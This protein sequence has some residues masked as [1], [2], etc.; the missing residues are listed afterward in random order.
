[1]KVVMPQMGES[2]VEGKLERWLVREGDTIKHDQP[3][4][5]VST[6]K[7]D[8]EI[9]SPCEGKIV[10][11]LVAEGE[12]VAVGCEL[13]VIEDG[14]GKPVVQ[15]ASSP[16]TP[17]SPI[18]TLAPLSGEKK[19]ELPSAATELSLEA[20]SA[21][22]SPAVRK[23]A[24]KYHVDLSKVKGTGMGGR[25]T[26]QDLSLIL[27]KEI[28]EEM[29]PEV[30][31]TPRKET[32]IPNPRP[33]TS[34]TEFSEYK[35]PHYEPKE[36]DQVVPFSRL[37][38]MISE[39]MV[40]SKRTAPHVTTVAEV[41]MMRVARLRE[42]KKEYAKKQFGMELTY[43]PFVLSATLAAISAHPVMNASVEGEALIIKKDINLGIA[44]DTERGLLVP[45][46]RRAQEKPLLVLSRLAADLAQKA[47]DGTLSPDE[48]TGGSFTVTNPGRTG[49]LFGTPI[50]F[51]PQ[52]GI[53]RMGELVKRPVVVE[54][55]GTDTVTIHPMM[56]LSLSYDHRVIDGATA[57]LFLH[58]VKE[59]LEEG[60]FS[61]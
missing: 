17:L 7:V 21:R 6:D 58:R 57:N 16:A 49:N 24:Q 52:V 11:I 14:R 9:P 23:M 48:V 2:V 53:L 34:E 36:G 29:P 55:D 31:E 18:F 26:K 12:T 46:I 5:E 40:Y 25:I 61:F 51:Q 13:A 37:R 56:H 33:K 32:A 19:V 10:R 3:I 60:C 50:I 39:H 1:M 20:S 8:V 35:I 22:L 44:V 45:V 47:R 54:V 38:K 15:E 4:A 43:L 42:G 27:G 41:D 30:E 59:I 28:A